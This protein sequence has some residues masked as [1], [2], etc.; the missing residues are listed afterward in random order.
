MYRLPREMYSEQIK[1]SIQADIVALME[2]PKVDIPTLSDKNIHGE[3]Q[4]Y[5]TISIKLARRQTFLKVDYQE[6]VL[7]F[8]ILF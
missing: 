4:K 6:I 3:I 1:N 8:L 2:V 5:E 7:S